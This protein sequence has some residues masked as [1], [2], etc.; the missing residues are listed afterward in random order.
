MIKS[1]YLYPEPKSSNEKF[2]DETSPNWERIIS[3]VDK[4]QLKES[5][6]LESSKRICSRV[7]RKDI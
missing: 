6:I 4:P 7:F 2:I 1:K 5:N 3:Q